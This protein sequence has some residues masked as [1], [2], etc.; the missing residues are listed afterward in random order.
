MQTLAWSTIL[1]RAGPAYNLQ[2]SNARKSYFSDIITKN[3]HYARSLF[4]TVDRRIKPPV[5][6]ATELHS[7]MA[8][9]D[10][11]K[12]FTDKVQNIRQAVGASAAGSACVPCPQKTGLNTMTLFQPINSKDLEDI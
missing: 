3:S 1:P 6:V 4:A 10:F 9:N 2:L 12:F 5:S 11:A 8:C 7:T